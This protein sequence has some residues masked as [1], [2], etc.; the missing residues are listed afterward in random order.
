VVKKPLLCASRLCSAIHAI[1]AHSL[2]PRA[3]YA[4]SSPPRPSGRHHRPA[5]AR[6]AGR[7][8]PG[9]GPA[10]RRGEAAG[11]ARRCSTAAGACVAT[12]RFKGLD[13]L[14]PAAAYLPLHV[15]P[16]PSLPPP[17]S[18]A[19]PA[20]LGTDPVLRAIGRA[21]ADLVSP[22]AAGRR[23]AMRAA[24]EE[25]TWRRHTWED[26]VAAF[27]LL[28][29]AALARLLPS[30]AGPPS[31]DGD[32]AG[33]ECR[34]RGRVAAGGYHRRMGLV[35]LRESDAPLDAGWARRRPLRSRGV[36][37]CVRGRNAARLP[38]RH[39]GTGAGTQAAM[40]AAPFGRSLA[41]GSWPV[42]S[43]AATA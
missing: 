3:T 37:T 6:T 29:R 31:G 9:P 41:A 38:L 43:P 27:L 22:A 42:P 35:V 11:A 7:R 25:A 39:A 24:A 2:P 20:D 15:A 5:A 18:N 16:H 4:H 14:L 21:V 17:P 40:R 19:T 30:A 1:Y 12:N 8:P 10:A 26:A 28:A 33:A 34:G 23:A 13:L 32:A 36:G